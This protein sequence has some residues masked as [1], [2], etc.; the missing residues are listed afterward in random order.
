VEQ[1]K[2]PAAPIVELDERHCYVRHKK[3][4]LDL[5]SC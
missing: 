4:L 5:D 2:C 1:I 3:L